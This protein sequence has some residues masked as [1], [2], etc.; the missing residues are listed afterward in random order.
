MATRFQDDH[1]VAEAKQRDIWDIADRLAILDLKE[2]QRNR[3]KVGPCPKCGGDDRFSVNRQKGVFYCRIC[4]AKGDV[5]NLVAW[6]MGV[7]F[8]GALDWLC[9]PRQELSPEERSRR[10]AEAAKHKA[11][12]DA[13]EHKYRQKAIADGR[14]IWERGQPA[15]DSAVRDYLQLRGIPR[16]LWPRLPVC[17]R[18]HP[19]L[20][21][22][23]ERRSADPLQVHRGPAMLAAVQGPD[24]R[25]TAVH[26][27]WIDL[28]RP[29]GK[30]LIL[31]PS[32]GAPQKNKKSMG[33]VKGSAIRLTGGLIRSVLVM[34]EGIETTASAMVSGI[35]P[36]AMFWAGI[37][38]GNMAGQRLM[39][40]GLR[41][42]GIPDLGD[43]EAFVPPPCV[44]RL[45]FIQD[46][47][48]DP[49][50][51]RAKLLAGLRRAMVLRPGLTAQI[52]HAGDGVDLNDVL[53]GQDDG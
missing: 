43:Q 25:F 38:L 26:R 29:R 37:S 46:G 23:V 11:A 22:M 15:E 20:P 8:P 36:D 14:R 31:D 27:T 24:N 3:E 49:K 17:L 45:I 7:D 9:G 47:D 51:T 34:G 33:H 13:A 19:D 5:I 12:R 35:Y 4:Q 42:S 6:V 32:D 52:V 21:Y 18:F 39:G 16:K 44:E 40:K 2:I 53:M 50:E 10:E 48:S 30:P 28:D 1:R 41:F